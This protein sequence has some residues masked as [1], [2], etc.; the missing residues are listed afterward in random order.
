MRD[1]DRMIR[2]RAV[3]IPARGLAAELGLLIARARNPQAQWRLLGLAA[4]CSDKFVDGANR[5]R[6]AIHI[7]PA[8]TLRVNRLRMQMRINEAWHYRFA[9]EVEHARLRPDEGHD[10]LLAPDGHELP[11]P[12]RERL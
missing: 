9:S 1:D 3:Q 4:E 7:R 11:I 8:R 10:E 6:L 12:Y 5:G 2:A